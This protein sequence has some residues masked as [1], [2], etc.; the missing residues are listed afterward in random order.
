MALAVSSSGVLGLAYL[1]NPFALALFLGLALD[2]R[3]ELLHNG[4]E[5]ERSIICHLPF[6]SV[7]PAD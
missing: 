2:Q 7:E 1:P 4:P 6:R 3:S 5:L